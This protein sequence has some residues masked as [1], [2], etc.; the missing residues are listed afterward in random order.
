MNTR[1]NKEQ[2]MPVFERNVVGG[3]S[4]TYQQIKKSKAAGTLTKSFDEMPEFNV[5]SMWAEKKLGI[6]K[7][8]PTSTYI[9]L[10]LTQ[11]P[12]RT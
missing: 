9:H 7:P 12:A 4:S 3:A 11:T 2:K 10:T 5:A 1:Q 6:E 8:V